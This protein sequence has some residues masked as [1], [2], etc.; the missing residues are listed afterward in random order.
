M[1]SG[2]RRSVVP[3]WGQWVIHYLTC[4]SPSAIISRGIKILPV[5]PGQV[6]SGV[7]SGVVSDLYM[8]CQ[9]I[10]HSFFY[11][12]YLIFHYG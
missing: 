7:E 9:A 5:E 10:G 3:E 1:V 8:E 2:H 12:I 6:W 11:L 4:L